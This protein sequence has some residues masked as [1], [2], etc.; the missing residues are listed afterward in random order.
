MKRL[1]NIILWGLVL[2]LTACEIPF[3]IKQE[4]E[5]RIYV[6]GVA[7]NGLVTVSTLY[8]TPIGGDSK[9]TLSGV[10]IDFSVNGKEVEL[11]GSPIPLEEGDQLLVEVSA[12][13]FETVRGSTIV[14]PR[15]KITDLSWERIQVDT[16]DA[17]EIRMILDHAPLDDEYYGIQI[18]RRDDV[19]YAGGDVETFLTYPTPGY[20]LTA[21]ESGN[22][23]LADF[24]QINYNGRYLGGPDYQP[25]TLL[26]KKQFDGALYKFYLNSFDASILDQIRNSMPG[27]DTGMVGGDIVSGEVGPGSGPG[28]IPGD[29]RIP[30]GVE[31]QYSFT[32]YRLS[33]E[34]YFYAKAL[35]QSNFDFLANMGLI[36]ANFTWSNVHGGLGFVG[37]V[38]STT[39]G[40][41]QFEN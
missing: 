21:A 17:T 18:L 38:T 20:I 30:L 22:F 1:L 4:G 9:T 31:T 26:T 28:T 36:P 40:P 32:F 7:D 2:S 14:P 25:I 29:I 11:H 6:Q 8:A 12:D 19:F 16:I 24:I 37:A 13:G 5:S 34:F 23:D 35:F 3:D 10:K 41:Y 27:G 39:M 15:P 33:P